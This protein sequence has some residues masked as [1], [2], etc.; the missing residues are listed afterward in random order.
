VIAAWCGMLLT[1]A[2]LCWNARRVVVNSAPDVTQLLLDWSSGS[3]EARDQLIPAV[4]RELR[5]LATR[6]LRRERADHT[7]QPTAL[8]HE[9]YLKLINQ[10][11]VRWQNRA[12][13]FGIAA[14]LMRR[15][16]V[17]HARSHGAHKRGS[18]VPALSLS[19]EAASVGQRQ[20][21]L[22]EV[23]VALERLAAID[24]RQERLVELRFFGGLTIEETAE[25]LGLSPSSV[26]REWALAKAWLYRE[27]EGR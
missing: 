24:P 27:L 6:Y 15:I 19:D 23:D 20:V 1:P 26:K 16:L 9:A 12:H 8:V 13:F 14:Q 4:Y 7:L 17:D 3:Q 5:Q 11:S 21:D 10:K 22:L 25:V 2:E 18:G